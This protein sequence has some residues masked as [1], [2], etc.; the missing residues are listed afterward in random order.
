MSASVKL[1]APKG[2]LLHVCVSCVCVCVCDINYRR[3]YLLA[4][5]FQLLDS[6]LRGSPVF[7]LSLLLAGS[8]RGS[9]SR[10]ALYLGRCLLCSYRGQLVPIA[11]REITSV[12]DTDGVRV[13]V[14]NNP[15]I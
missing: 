7:P 9:G 10:A 3:S 5:C 15:E 14:L 13:A 11:R 6:P 4:S 1:L 12:F 2:P 8:T